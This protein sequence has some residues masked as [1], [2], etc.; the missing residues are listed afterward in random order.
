MSLEATWHVS[1]A[2]LPALGVFLVMMIVTVNASLVRAV[3]DSG[4]VIDDFWFVATLCE[5]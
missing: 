4:L 1:P 3:C 2:N 5:A